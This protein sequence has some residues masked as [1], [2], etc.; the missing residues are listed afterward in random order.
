MMLRLKKIINENLSL[1]IGYAFCSGTAV[2]VDIS[3]LYSLTTYTGIWYFYSAIMSYVLSATVNFTLN[4]QLNFKNKSRSI[5][6]QFSDFNIVAITGLILN[7][8]MLYALVE[9]F[10]IWY[11][12][13]R[14]SSLVIISGL[15]FYLHKNITFRKEVQT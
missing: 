8:I 7:Q 14:L 12:Y 1:F 3:A 10:N 9:Y 2:V 5:S 6:R 15:S 13:A 11:I 4:R